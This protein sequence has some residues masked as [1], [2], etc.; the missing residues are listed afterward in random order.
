MRWNHGEQND[1]TK[2]EL[3]GKWQIIYKLKDPNAPQSGYNI[4]INRVAGT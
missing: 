4:E 3:G 2:Q 1:F